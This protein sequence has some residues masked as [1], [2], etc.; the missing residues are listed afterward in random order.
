MKRLTLILLLLSQA[1]RAEFYE[2]RIYDVTPGKLDA[3]IERFRETV[4][5]VRR[6]HEIDTVGYWTASATNGEKFVYLIRADSESQ[7][8][9]H[10]K[11]FV[12]DPE[13]KKGYAASTSKHGKTVEKITS[14][15]LKSEDA[16]KYEISGAA[17]DLRLYTILPGK[18]D[19]FRARWRDHAVQIYARHGLRSC[20][21]WTAEKDGQTFFIC[22]LAAKDIAA[23][24]QSI[25]E[26][27]SDAEWKRVEEDS[28]RNGKLR[29]S[30]TS[31]QLTLVNL[32]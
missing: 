16:A 23:I 25:S 11:A 24:K 9:A 7:L 26:F 5:P 13:F 14:I 21:W 15:P 22:L 3:V 20:G 18:L 10:E 30:V 19:E 29:S 8:R 27:H 31:L 32:K 4:E 12:D 17:L 2:L 1:V 28:E 6:K